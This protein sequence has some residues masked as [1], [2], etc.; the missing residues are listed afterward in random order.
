MA[1]LILF[2]AMALLAPQLAPYNPAAIDLNHRLMPPGHAHWFG[3][4]ELGRDGL[5]LLLAGG[6]AT[7][8]VALPAALLAFATGLGYGLLGL[9][10]AGSGRAALPLVASIHHPISVD[11]RIDLAALDTAR[12]HYPDRQLVAVDLGT[13]SGA[14]ALSI[15][16]EHERV[17]VWATDRSTAALDVASANLAGL[18]GHSATRVR[19]AQG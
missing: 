8:E 1:L 6:Q 16:A 10:R 12:D 4:D 18:G 19:L 7:L 9:G 13:G 17:V 3:T 11:K 15:A 5:A 14:I 2:A